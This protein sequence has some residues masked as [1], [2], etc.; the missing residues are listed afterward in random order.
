MSGAADDGQLERAYEAA[1][2]ILKDPNTRGYRLTTPLG[3]NTWNFGR[4]FALVYGEKETGAM[5]SHMATMFMNAL[6][7]RGFARQG[8]EV[9]TSIYSLC[10]DTERAK[11]YPGIPEYVTHE[12]RGMYHYLTGSAS[13][14]L[15]TVLTQILG[16]RGDYGDLHI[17]PKLVREQFDDDGKAVARVRFR[18]KNLEV[19]YTNGAGKDHGEYRIGGVSI[20]GVDAD[21]ETTED[22]AK[23]AMG[24]L[25]ELAIRDVNQVDVSLV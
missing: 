2:A 21:H 1:G 8:Y 7:R 14:L 12:A 13:W 20:N 15:M 23:I 10:M 19:T 6:Y 24:V 5:F 25:E 3:P 11:I 22:G 4:G 9:L 17:A 18:G 16:V